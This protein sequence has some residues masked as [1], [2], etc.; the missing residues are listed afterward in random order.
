MT[1]PIAET[2]RQGSAMLLPGVIHAVD[3]PNARVRLESGGWVSAWLPWF[4]VAAGEVRHWRPPSVG[5]QAFLV[6]PS[7]M[8]EQGFVIPGVYSDQHG[9]ANDNREQITATDWPDGAREHYDHD[10]HDYRHALPASGHVRITIG[11][12]TSIDLWNGKAVVNVEDGS[13]LT[14]TPGK[15]TLKTPFFLVDSPLTKFKGVIDMAGAGG[16]GGLM[17]LSGDAVVDGNVIVRGGGIAA[18]AHLDSAPPT[19]MPSPPKR[20]K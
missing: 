15:T 9:Q 4:S 8:P 11:D 16:K 5:E 18:W 6:N 7:G 1:Y 20:K 12:S 19:P 14:M 17:H 3:Y 10:E 2:D 13:V